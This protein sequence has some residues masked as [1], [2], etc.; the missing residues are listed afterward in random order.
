MWPSRPL[1]KPCGIER[2]SGRSELNIYS[3][4][5]VRLRS[6][7]VLNELH[8]AEPHDQRDI[9]D[10]RLG[11]LPE[12]PEEPERN[13]TRFRFNGDTADFE[14]RGVARY[15][16]RH[17]RE[18]TVDPTPGA[19]ERSVRLFLL[20]S[21]LGLLSHQRGLLPLHANAV[22]IDGHA[23]AF[24]GK[25]GAGK[26]TLAAHFLQ[27]AKRVLCDDVCVVSFDKKGRPLAWPG[28]PRVKLW[29][30]ALETFGHDPQVLDRAVEGVEKYHVPMA[31]IPEY[32]PLPLKA[33]YILSRVKPGHAT[34]ERLRGCEAMEALI[35]NTYRSHYLEPMGL[36]ARHFS[37]CHAL[38]RHVGVYSAARVWGFDVFDDEVSRIERHISDVA[39][40]D[41]GY[42]APA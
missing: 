37:Q 15:R 34:I 3:C 36:L 32:A 39:L 35:A 1:Y 14:V 28:L 41:S 11:A 4:L 29:A 9:V 16:V 18:I 8:L 6:E 19:S 12:I 38:L 40:K 33:V 10:I 42:S 25:S 24:S 2:D 31:P 30:D 22:V 27:S 13:R 5:D 26:S 17:G 21:G 20:G 7:I 23:V